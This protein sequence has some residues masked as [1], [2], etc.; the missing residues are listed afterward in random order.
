MIELV[1]VSAFVLLVIAAGG[2]FHMLNSRHMLVWL[3]QYLRQTM[4]RKPPVSRPVHVLFCFVDHYEPQWLR[5]DYATEVSRVDSWVDGYPKIADRHKDADGVVPQHSFFYPE[6]EYREEHLAKLADLCRR[7]YGEIEVHLHH[8]E[9]TA[10]NFRTT[11]AEFVRKLHDNHGA[12]SRDPDTGQL[13]WAFIHGN[14]SLCNSLPG[15]FACGINEEL[16][17]LRELGCYCDMTLPSA[18][19]PAQ[20][21]TINSI[22]YAEDKP[23]QPKSHDTGVPVRVGGSPSGD[24]MIVQGP[25]ALNWRRRKRGIFPSIENGDIK[26]DNPPTPDRIDLWIDA[27][28]HV[29]G[30]PEWRF[31]KVH[32]HGAQ[33]GDMATCLGEPSDMM[34]DYLETKYNDGKDYVLHYVTAREMYNIVKAAEAGETGNPGNYRDYRLPKPSYIKSGEAFVPLASGD[35]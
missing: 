6:E 3:P 34:Y 8:H 12:F 35:A 27:G 31:V 9:D 21:S 10:E 17:I 24:L 5:P 28:V 29:E 25:L 16:P 26:N 20:T 7:G 22:Y 14:W 1:L 32:T 19:S 2:L 23:G 30:R 11:L 18:P 33:E 13:S 4:R 15:G